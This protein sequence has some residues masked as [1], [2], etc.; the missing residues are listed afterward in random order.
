MAEAAS[1]LR[2]RVIAA[3]R[4]LAAT[5]LSPQMSGNVSARNG[6]SIL[7]TPSGIPYTALS[8]DDI[9][10]IAMDGQV[11]AGPHAPSSEW[12]MHA[13]IYEAFP[14]A[15]GIVHAHSDFATVLAV[16]KRE[17]PPFHYMVAVAGGR[18]IRVAD[19]ATFGTAELARNA[20]AA[21]E[22]R[23]AC[24]LAH[25]GQIAIGETVEAALH[26]AHEVETLSAQYWRA[27]QLGEPDL[28]SD[29]VMSLNVEKFRTYGRKP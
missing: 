10:E 11:L 25:H 27:L 20:V 24:L 9:S 15:G 29:E 16:M 22:G 1:A 2:A 12:Q 6:G 23:R 5:G 28:L 4:N 17:I 13:A 7:I 3:A 19:Y 14:D 8:P 18:N 21:L 26:L